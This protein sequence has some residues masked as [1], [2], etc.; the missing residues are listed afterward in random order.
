MDALLNFLTGMPFW[1]WWAFALALL[2]AEL[3]LPSTF[4]LWPAGGALLS[5]LAALWPLGGDWRGQLAVFAVATVAFALVGPKYVRPFYRQTTDSKLNA[6]GE[7]LK[8]ASAI[9]ETAFQGGQGKVKL[10]D[11]VWLATSAQ[12]E[13]FEIGARVTV[14]GADG[15]MLIVE[16]AGGQG[17]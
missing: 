11:T 4:L 6:R 15:A 5:G 1:A 13:D 12:G 8:G 7:R 14:A 2:A 9:V 10:G 16:Q 17:D 3:A